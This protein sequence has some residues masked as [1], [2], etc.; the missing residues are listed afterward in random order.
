[1]GV[2]NIEDLKIILFDENRQSLDVT[3]QL[4]DQA[5]IN[6]VHVLSNRDRALELCLYTH[7]DI[8]LIDMGNSNKG[9]DLIAEL[10]KAAL[11]QKL[12]TR[13]LAL[14]GTNRSDAVL[15]AASC[16]V[17]SIVIKPIA[18]SAI[19]DRIIM[20]YDNAVNYL[21]FD[22]YHGPDRRLMPDGLPAGKTDR[23][24]IAEA[25]D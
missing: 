9:R 2:A 12:D 11:T 14:I 18:A 23:R 21:T 24:E 16:G 22:G 8:V 20:T 10:R 13:I 19:K 25:A 17:D 5:E 15:S 7:V 4:L 3:K 1:M 6:P